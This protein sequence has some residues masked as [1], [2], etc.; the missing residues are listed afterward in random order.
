MRKQLISWATLSTVALLALAGCPA[1]A[2]TSSVSSEATSSSLAPLTQVKTYRTTYSTDPEVFNSVLTN[3]QPNSQHIANFIDGLV[4]N[5]NRGRIVPALA[6]SWESEVL[7]SGKQVWTFDIRDTNWVD[8]S[9]ADFSPAIP[10]VADDWVFSVE[11]ALDPRNASEVVYLIWMFVEG[12]YD[13]YADME[14]Y[15]WGPQLED[16]NG[17]PVYDDDGYPVYDEN[18]VL[19][20][21]LKPDMADVGIKAVDAKTLE[22]TLPKEM[23][24]FPTVLTYSVFFPISRAVVEAKGGWESYG[25]LTTDSAAPS[26][27]AYNGAFLLD[28]FVSGNTIKYKKNPKY[29]DAANVG[30]DVVDMTYVPDDA[31]ASWSREKYEAGLIDSFRV[32]ANDVAGWDAYVL[33]T[34]GTGTDVNPAHEN[35]YSVP[36]SLYGSSYYMGFNFKRPRPLMDTN[37]NEAEVSNFETAIKN[38]H[39]RRAIALA[40]D[41]GALNA[42]YTPASPN[43]WNV[44][45]YTISG[46]AVDSN[47]KDYTEYVYEEFAAQNDMTVAEARALIAPSSEGSGLRDV[48]A[49]RAEMVLAYNELQGEVT[50]PVNLEFWFTMNPAR[51]P[52]Q[53][54]FVKSVSDALSVIDVRKDDPNSDDPADTLAN[55]KFAVQT[56]TYY[57]AT[58]SNAFYD[59]HFSISTSF[60]WGP[61]YGDP[62]TYLNTFQVGGD[63]T[64]NYGLD[65]DELGELILGDYTDLLN[66]ADGITDLEDRFAKFAEAEYKLLF[67]DAV[68]IPL[69]RPY[70]GVDV[71]VSKVEPYTALTALYGNSADKLK[72]LVVYNRA[73]TKEEVQAFRDAYAAGAE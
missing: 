50:F 46:L 57:T 48:A 54:A 37:L 20:P 2:T 59:H 72:S 69:M 3:E 61:D 24:Y 23:A 55:Y 16:E 70:Q 45:T 62:L 39:F 10:V 36:S 66:E 42:W 33:G 22:F 25:V 38:V 34:D 52:Y 58:S 56:S 67:E 32:T 51:T 30:L 4:E 14:Y 73:L 28:E 31:G 7:D 9:G 27:I 11:Q 35:A 47:G 65:A 68:I 18:W 63:L 49:A 6:E 71:R 40:V 5:D 64:P 13:Y 12:S 53:Q 60:G 21:T 17:D 29:W 8:E 26:S 1:A 44:H 19:D 43:Q 41:K 15:L